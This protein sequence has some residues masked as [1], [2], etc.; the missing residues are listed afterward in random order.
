[1]VYLQPPAQRTLVLRARRHLR[2]QARPPDWR[3][4]PARTNK[5][6]PLRIQQSCSQQMLR[7]WART[8]RRRKARPRYRPCWPSW[9]NKP[10][11]LLR[12]RPSRSQR[13]RRPGRRRGRYNVDSPSRTPLRRVSWPNTKARPAPR[14]MS[15]RPSRPYPRSPSLPLVPRTPRSAGGSPRRAWTPPSQK[16][17]R[18]RV[19]STSH[20][21]LPRAPA[22][23]SAA[24]SRLVVVSATTPSTLVFG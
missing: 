13:M 5:P 8:F 24:T 20:P 2:R 19:G 3:R 21:L 7:P 18:S 12:I 16:N 4:W 14:R 22:H 10:L 17:L 1:M 23:V 9:P 6:L 11:P 15:S